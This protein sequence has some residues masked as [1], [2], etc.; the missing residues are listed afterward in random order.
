MQTAT[1]AGRRIENGTRLCQG[2]DYFRSTGIQTSAVAAGSRVRVIVSCMT[3]HLGNRAAAA[4]IA[5]AVV[6]KE[7]AMAKAR[8]V[9][10]TRNY[11]PS[12]AQAK[13]LLLYLPA[14][15]TTTAL[16]SRNVVLVANR[17]TSANRNHEKVE[18]EDEAERDT[19]RVD[20]PPRRRVLN[21]IIAIIV[22][23]SVGFFFG[24][25]ILE[26]E[27]IQDLVNRQIRQEDD[28]NVEK[29]LGGCGGTLLL[30]TPVELHP[31][32]DLGQRHYNE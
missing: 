4:P 1:D 12:T 9:N 20:S 6:V 15:L 19:N 5:A 32:H 17:L 23:I 8:L 14:I 7:I 30:T 22:A 26:H 28:G 13:R 18:E 25:G 10:Q 16:L 31:R 11:H 3:R 24:G 29:R 2:L 27:H 21:H